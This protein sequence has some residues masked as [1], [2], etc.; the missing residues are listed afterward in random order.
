MRGDFPLAGIRVVDLTQYVAGPYC[1]QVLADLGATVLKLERSGSG[2]VYRRQ[3]PVFKDG[4]SASFLTLNR[5]KRS[6]EL[7]LGDESDRARLLG[8][9]EQ[10]DVLVENM[11]PGSLARFGLDYETLSARFPR[12]VYCSIS[13]F[14][15]RGPLAQAGGYDLTIQAFSG[16]MAMTGH[17]GGPPA[18]IPVAAL[19]FGSALYGVVGILAALRQRDATG[20][21]QWVTTSIL[22]CALA[23]LSM[24]IVTLLLG[25]EEPEPL[26]TRS[27][28]FAPYEAYRTADGYM[29]VVGTGGT[30]SWGDLCRA[31]GL[32]A[33]VEDPRFATNS[34]RVRNA[35]ELRHELETV[36][37]R[38]P[39][40]H[41]VELL[42]G[43]GIACA[44]VQGLAHV[45]ESDQVRVLEMLQE[46]RHSKAGEIPSVRLPLSFSAARATATDPPPTLGDGNSRRGFED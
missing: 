41:W 17:P 44:P 6:V 36:L 31:L 12:L 14:G 4:E 16:L 13:G 39:T 19:D 9:L 21:G 34:D 11:R 46:V 23:W 33:L 28:F 1:T 35:E 2:D 8:L 24:H 22:E 43:A 45:L 20:R 5:G 29:V 10:A 42:E 18:K 32:E 26:G 40:V 3:G 30:D 25:G 15:Q 38:E 7:D 37:T 27:P